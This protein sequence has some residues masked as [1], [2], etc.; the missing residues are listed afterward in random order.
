MRR[1]FVY[2]IGPDDPQ[3][4]IVKI[5]FSARPWSRLESLQG[6]APFPLR[7]VAEAPGTPL[8]EKALHYRFVGCWHYGE[9][10]RREILLERFIEE[11]IATQLLPKLPL[12]PPDFRLPHQKAVRPKNPNTLPGRLASLASRARRSEQRRRAP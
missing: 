1:G 3:W 11:V 12:A 5:G 6:W 10:F 2:F 4:R 9:W 8:D 7:I